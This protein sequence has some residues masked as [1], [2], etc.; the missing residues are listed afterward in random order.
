MTWATDPTNTKIYWLNGMAGTGKTTIAYTFSEILDKNQMLG[1]S[2]FCSRL[3]SGLNDANIIFPT[4]AYELARRIPSVTGFVL[5]A[6]RKDDTVGR[7]VMNQQFFNLIVTP[8]QAAS[9][10][11]SVIIVI[12]A[13]DECINQKAVADMLSVISQYS[14]NLPIKFFITSRPEPQ[15]QNK[16]DLPHFE[17]HSKIFLHNVEDSIVSADI[18]IY[19][20]G[21]FKNIAAERHSEVPADGWPSEDQLETIVR[22]ADKL[23]IYAATVC[24]YV[25]EGRS[26]QLR[27]KVATGPSSASLNGKTGMLDDLY[28]HILDAAYRESDEQE[29]IHVA[30]VLRAVISVC[31]PLSIAGLSEL[32]HIDSESIRAALLSLNSVIYTP[33]SKDSSMTSSVTTFHASFPDYI[34]DRGR[35]ACNF[36]DPSESHQLLALRCLALMQSSLKENI[37]GLDGQPDNNKIPHS[38]INEHISEGL[39]YACTYWASHVADTRIQGGRVDNLFA[40]LYQFFDQ[41]VLQWIECL[42]LIGKW[43]TAMDILERVENWAKVC[44]S[45]CSQ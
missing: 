27:L 23:F 45:L 20:R 34:N 1:A 19:V 39:A 8:V 30:S 5:D 18:K 37:C 10:E 36:L 3:E 33:P 15:I 28:G 43:E 31:N 41:S 2:F 24:E 32:L 9:K 16:F 6:L 4:I 14:A 40:A 12:D 35:S 7:K 13:L 29:K 44:C 22:R 38:T 42:S 21:R 11:C 26:V 17:R 25:A